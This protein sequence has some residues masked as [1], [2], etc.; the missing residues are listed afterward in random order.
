MRRRIGIVL[1]FLIALILVCVA[2]P[3]ASS[4]A[5]TATQRL[6]LDRQAD[7][8]YFAQLAGNDL[9]NGQRRD[10][11]KELARYE[12]LYGIRAVVIGRDGNMLTSS[13][14]DRSLTPAMARLAE[15][16]LFSGRVDSTEMIWPWDDDP[17]ITAMP[18]YSG[19]E[20]VGAA[21][22]VSP[23]G[24]IRA[25]ILDGWTVLLFVGV[26]I[27]GLAVL[28]I[29]PIIRWILRPVQILYKAATAITAGKFTA[30]ADPYSGPPELRSLAQAFNQMG[31]TIEQLIGR[32]E[33]FAS[34]ASH[35][36]R[37]PLAVLRLQLEELASE[38]RP[39]AA[40]L[41][42]SMEEVDRL[43]GLCNSLLAFAQIESRAVVSVE[44]NVET[45]ADDRVTAW[46]QFAKREDVL[47]RRT[48]AGQILAQ[49]SPG[50]LAQVLDAL[51]DNAIKFSGPGGTVIVHV[52]CSA[53]WAEV[54]VSDDGP[55]MSPASRE[56]AVEPFWRNDD[57]QNIPGSGLGL[58]ICSTLI[59]RVGG[60]FD[61]L[62][63]RPHGLVARVR[64]PLAAPVEAERA[65]AR[66]GGA[67]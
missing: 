7:T 65:A 9:P 37:T 58:T 57:S 1:L 8:E 56:R 64:L 36:L 48:G 3:F 53:K 66:Q 10:I 4:T 14:A 2:L 46:R 13:S 43:S 55:G 49:S 42:T 24:E 63:A 5:R 41:T 22:T 33:A 40:Q 59:T 45:I 39:A 67:P 15:A 61:L 34:H 16:A 28:V 62:T 18:V 20:R 30:R 51:I 38:H 32:Q 47:L 52:G 54:R 31:D 11:T 6:E 60:Q 12:K 50:M 21:L 35:Q 26:A 29:E 25:E 27:L 44:E 17:F 23:T 19:G